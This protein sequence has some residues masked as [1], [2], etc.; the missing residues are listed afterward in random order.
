MK[1]DS[2]LAKLIGSFSPE[3]A[4][5]VASDA[6]MAVQA[7]F[8]AFKAAAQAETTE[9]ST[10]LTTALTAVAEADGKVAELTTQLATLTTQLSVFTAQVQAAKLAARKEKLVAA[11]GTERADALMESTQGVDDASFETVV[12]A[13]TLSTSLES[14][15]NM[16][17]EK[18]ADAQADASKTVAVE[19][20]TMKIVK[21]RVAAGLHTTA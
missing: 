12:S 2:M 4:E 18:G 19:S 7:E 15:S 5:A 1:K 17:V 11:V 3:A 6:T 21:Q 20:E 10:A 9:L 8:D 13:L 14:Q 16:F